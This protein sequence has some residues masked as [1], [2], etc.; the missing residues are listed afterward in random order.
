MEIAQIYFKTGLK[1]IK[2][3]NLKANR[4]NFENEDDFAQ[5]IGIPED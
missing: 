2:E 1:L 4:E 3:L 5:S